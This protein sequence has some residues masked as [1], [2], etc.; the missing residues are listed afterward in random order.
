MIEHKRQAS[1]I[2]FRLEPFLFQLLLLALAYRIEVA[3]HQSGET[4]E[5]NCSW[6]LASSGMAA[7]EATGSGQHVL[8][9][10]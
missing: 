6:Q 5:A 1:T 8:C 4:D 10:K 3:D 9:G 7:A 2:L